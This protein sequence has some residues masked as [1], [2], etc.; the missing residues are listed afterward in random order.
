MIRTRTKDLL[1]TLYDAALAA[2]APAAA[3]HQAFAA[4]EVTLELGRDRRHWILAVGK[5]AAAMAAAA[6]DA[7]G[8]RGLQV[9]G[10]LVVAASDAGSASP[11]DRAGAAAIPHIVGDHPVPGVR[12]AEAAERVGALIERIGRDDIVIVCISGGTSSLIGAPIA[13]V[14]SE[15]LASLNA[16]LLG[17]GVPIGRINAVR[18]RF[19]RFGAGRL[20][21]GLDCARV[22]PILLADVPNEDPAMIGSGPLSPDPLYAWQ[23]ERVLR[24]AGLAVRVPLS[25]A[26][27]L[28]AMRAEAIAETPKPGSE[29]FA[30]VVAPFVVGNGAAL[31]AAAS[32]AAQAGYAPV[33]LSRTI[34]TGDATAA[35]RA[36]AH[37][38]ARAAPGS[39]L[40]WGGETT[41]HLPDDHGLGGRCQQLALAAAE[42]LD[43][44]G[45][46]AALLAAGTDGQDGLAPAAGALVDG[47]TW[48]RS[49]AAGADP[50]RALARCDAYGALLAADAILPQ[51]ETGTNVMDIVVA[52][53]ER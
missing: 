27:T 41:V 15:D 38:I 19:A 20:A 52:V 48:A 17:A 7:C 21:A 35:G 3:V 50:A 12:S 51:R 44:L 45:V 23:V 39:C 9:A 36:I 29:V 37:A 10:G 43:D 8:Q 18:K 40:I 2:A 28:G 22:I 30:R 33:L 47:A 11:E 25:I 26:S 53:R 32:A 24:D 42:L 6:V 13:G 34:L 14:R 49:R 4:N 46:H 5:A 16:L 1:P 31:E